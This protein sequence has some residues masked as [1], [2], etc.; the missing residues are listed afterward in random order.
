MSMKIVAVQTGL[1]PHSV[2]GGTVTDRE[3]LTR[4]ADRGAQVHVLAEDG[5]PIVS[6]PGLIPHFWRR[7]LRKKVPFVS[8]VDVAWDLRKLLRRVGPVDWI[9]FNNPYAVGIG[10]LAAA[11]ST[12]TWASYL[13]CEPERL[14]RWV[15]GWLPGRC[16][17][18]TC[19]SEDTRRDVVARCPAADREST[20]VIPMGI[21]ARR[22]ET[23]G[24]AREVVRRELGVGAET[25]LV[26]FAG[27]LTARKGIAELVSVWQRLGSRPDA[28]LLLL[29]KPISTHESGLVAELVGRDPRVIHLPG[30]PY[31]T[32]PEYFRASDVFFFPTRL[33]GFGIVVGEAMAAGLPVVTTRAQGVREVVVEGDSALASEVGD[34]EGLARDLG[35]LLASAS[36]RARLGAGGRRRIQSAFTWDRTID[37]LW[38][39]LQRFGRPSAAGDG[40]SEERPASRAAR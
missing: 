10:A 17:M 31:E 20:V 28:R 11:G 1:S 2:L 4:L 7:R 8:N 40:R 13:H 6:H 39:A 34:V 33:E 21:D 32:V 25:T 5:E 18:V 36:E 37:R 22:M 30:V 12:P 29:S 23:A 9:R 3:F 16:R 38:E 14:L 19:L 35:S 15:D 24:R 26:L 27:V